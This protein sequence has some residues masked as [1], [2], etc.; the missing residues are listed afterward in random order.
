MLKFALLPADIVFFRFASGVKPSNLLAAKMAVD[1][2]PL[3]RI[4][5]LLPGT[6]DS[7]DLGVKE[8]QRNTPH[9]SQK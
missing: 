2:V 7:R 4:S 9:E 3:C 5:W 1:P 8:C 6:N